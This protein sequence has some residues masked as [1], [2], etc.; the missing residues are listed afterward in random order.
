MTPASPNGPDP[1]SSGGGLATIKTIGWTWLDKMIQVVTVLLFPVGVLF[2]I[3]LS[4]PKPPADLLPRLLGIVV[5]LLGLD[6]FA[7][8]MSSV[9]QVRVDSTGVTFR[10]LFHSTHR[11]WPDLAPSNLV[12]QHG[13]W[14]VVSRYHNGRRVRLQRG[15]ALTIEQAR[16]LVTHPNCPKWHLSEAIKQG[17]GVDSAGS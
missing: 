12:P 4:G 5:F 14:G 17:L 1:G 15:Y 6:V 16:A 9:R 7:E 10:Y 3:Y 11:D 8:S 13:G 2:V